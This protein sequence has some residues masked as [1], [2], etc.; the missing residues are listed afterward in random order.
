VARLWQCG[1]EL[2]TLTAGVEVSTTSGTVSV[3]SS[4]QRTGSYCLRTNPSAATAFAR[5]HVH[6]SD[7]STTCFF[8]AYLKITTLPGANMS[9]IRITDSGN[10]QCAQVRLTS[11]GT[12]VL[13]DAGS[14]TVGSASSALSTGTWYLVEVGV[15]ASTNP[16]TVT[17][18]LDGVQVASGANSAQSPWAR[19]VVGPVASATC[20]LLWDDLAVNDSTG[21]AQTSWPGE[22]KIVHLLPNGAGDANGWSNTANGAGS[23]S[24]YQLVDEVPP[25]DT[26]DLVQTG[27]LNAE[28]MYA[29]T[30]SGI[31]AADTVNAVMVG[32]RLRNNTA[33]PSAA[34]RAQIKKTTGGTI[35]QGSA[36]SLNSTSFATNAPAEPRNYTLV[37]YTDPDG[38]AWTQATLD[39]AQ[40]GIKLTTAGTQR[41]Q[42]STLWVSV[43]YT[44]NPA[45]DATA[46]PSAVA[47]T[48]AVPS[49]AV[50][51]GAGPAP[52][53]VA[54]IAAAPSAT[55]STG[56]TTSLASVAG[57]AAVPALSLS[58]G[59]AATPAPVAGVAA[60]ET[61]TVAIGASPAPATVN[62]S[63]ALP[64]PDLSTG[65]AATPANVA[66]KGSI[67]GPAVTAVTSVSPAAVAGAAGVPAPAMS[68]G[69]TATATAVAGSVSISGPLVV[70]SP[71][72]DTVAAAAA[73]PAPVVSTSVTVSASPVAAVA[74]A[75]APSVSTSG[76]ASAAPDAVAVP[77]AVPIPA[78]SAGATTSP[79]AVA[80]AAAVGA[81]SPATGSTSEPSPVAAA[82]SAPAP[83]LSTSVTATPAAVTSTATIPGPQVSAG[84]GATAT[85][86][87]VAGAVT[88]PTV[89]VLASSAIQAATVALS[90]VVPLPA[91][92]AE[93]AA[94]DVTVAAGPLSRRWATRAM[95][96]SWSAGTP[97]T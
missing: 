70:T 87:T 85:P 94:I 40:A 39:T 6:A 45:V 32:I 34:V 23:T 91:V 29:L 71:S 35:A 51:T 86:P 88:V 28:D 60:V 95:A 31:G 44:P 8:R 16:G 33:D 10:F 20:D 13:L 4:G 62:A 78:I 97:H 14:G 22:G 56:S 68:A 42:V 59:S 84:T 75:P 54:G 89:S 26:T 93:G 96:R 49:A 30:N 61:T 82:A 65:S 5:Y 92:S 19:V 1:F 41:V 79:A 69:S 9:A 3:V 77:A 37:R 74:A 80:S 15:D 25:N 46:T 73:V 48:A 11:S 57:T 2:G 83:T 76:E 72:P 21:S 12:L 52:A 43:D 18:R 7:Q 67:P 47:G 24:N 38:A 81:P 36:I 66:A 58:T 27:T 50:S 63:A 55:V 64:S 17:L 90:A 53:A